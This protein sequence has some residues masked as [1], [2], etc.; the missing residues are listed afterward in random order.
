MGWVSWNEQVWTGLQWWPPDVSS[1]GR[2]WSGYPIS[3]VWG[4]GWNGDGD[5]RSHVQG[6]REG[7]IV[8]QGKGMYPTNW[9]YPMM[10]VM[11]P[12]PLWTEWQILRL[13]AVII[14]VGWSTS[15]GKP[16]T[17]HWKCEHETETYLEIHPWVNMIHLQVLSESFLSLISVEALKH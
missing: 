14:H 7:G 3:H 2:G 1:S 10:H 11:L 6:S 12:I 4:M 9:T 8:V 5:P 13:L 16:S 15:S 17:R